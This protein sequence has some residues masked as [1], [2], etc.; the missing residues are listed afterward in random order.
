VRICLLSYRGNPYSGGQ[1]IYVHYL[2]RE[3][4]RLGHEVEVYSGP[5][6]PELADGV[7]LT[8]IKSLNLYEMDGAHPFHVPEVF[9]PLNLYEVTAAKAGLFPEPF[10][11]SMRAFN[12]L[13]AEWPRKRFDVIHDNQSLAYGLLLMKRLGV[14]VVATLHHPIPIDRNA[15]LA[16][17]EGVIAKL[18]LLGWYSFTGMQGSVARRLERM[19]TVSQSSLEESV[20]AFSIDPSRMRVVYN[21][22]D[23]DM[24][25]PMEVPDRVPESVIVTTSGNMAVKGL[26]YLLEAA[27]EL[28]R[29]RPIRVTVVG[30]D[31]PASGG[32][33]LA[34]KL[35]LSDIV[36]FTGRVETSELVHQYASHDVA[37][38]P[39][40]Y[41]G[42]GLPAAEAM[43]CGLPVVATSAGALP[44]VVGPDGECGLL[45]PPADP[46]ALARAIER[47]LDDGRL[48]LQMGVAARKR[49]VRNFTWRQ[50][51]CRT[52]EVYQELRQC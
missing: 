27:A 15:E 44:E 13:K 51:A 35:G 39:S 43:A 42:F 21:G 3:L 41:E 18:R 17:M 52:V 14:P 23:C 5:P 10:T 4:V 16:E 40:L 22:V 45:V 9:H 26:R 30:N 2:S 25:R 20:R 11:F 50:A 29:H 48:R 31:D 19:I 36:S 7:Q 24:F 32:P 1:G 12:R 28:R 34:A 8:K 47:L 46:G 6:Y 38:V 33:R 37:V 49:V